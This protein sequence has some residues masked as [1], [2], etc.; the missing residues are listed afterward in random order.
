MQ[1]AILIIPVAL[2]SQANAV[3]AAMAWGPESYTIPL[4][5]DGSTVTHWGLRA[6]VDE[7]FAR[8]ITG[9]DPLPD[10]SAQ[11]VVDALIADFST[12]D[13]GEAHLLR[14]LE[15]NGFVKP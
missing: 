6:D 1:S 2:L 3:G 12:S 7:Q 10:P 9:L 14:V 13:W 15:E 11:P 4:S 5:D 8:W